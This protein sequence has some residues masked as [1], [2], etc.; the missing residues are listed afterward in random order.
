MRANYER[1]CYGLCCQ[2]STIPDFPVRARREVV[3]SRGRGCVVVVV[4]LVVVMLAVPLVLARPETVDC[5]GYVCTCRAEEDEMD[6]VDEEDVDDVDD[7]L[8]WKCKSWEDLFS[9]A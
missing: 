7:A 2:L 5:W 8:P 6:E 3:G 1:T 9:V 4:V